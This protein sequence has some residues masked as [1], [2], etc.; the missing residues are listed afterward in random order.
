MI[1]GLSAVSS[2]LPLMTVSLNLFRD[3]RASGRI[4]TNWPREVHCCLETPF[5]MI[6]FSRE[7]VLKKLAIV[8]P[9]EAIAQ[10]AIKALDR[11]SHSGSD[12][13]IVHVVHIAI[14]KLSEGKL[15]QLREAVQ[16][17]RH[18]FRDV[19]SARPSP[20]TN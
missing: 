6:V 9:D 16:T 1:T 5:I 4:S 11:Y 7:L 14:I 3:R 8:F 13:A 15:W 17:A 18:D 19:L 12:P 2:A 20:R 10:Q